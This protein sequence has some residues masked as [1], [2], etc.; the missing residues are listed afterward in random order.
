MK[1]CFCILTLNEESQIQDC[2]DSTKLVPHH[3]FI[4]D[5]GSNDKTIQIIE[6]N[7]VD[8]YVNKQSSNYCA[9]TQ[10]NIGLKIAKEYGYSHVFFID[11]DER[12]NDSSIDFINNNIN[13]LA[14]YE[15]VSIPLKYFLYGTFVRSQG[16]PNWHDRIVS[17]DSKFCGS[18]G[19]HINTHSKIYVKELNL[20]H[21]FNSKG[22]LRLSSNYSRYAS[23]IGEELFNYRQGLDSDYYKKNDGNGALKRYA[24]KLIWSRPFARFFW[25]YFWKRGFL[26]GKAGLILAIHNAYFELLIAIR[27][28]ELKRT[29]EG[30]GL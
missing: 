29:K 26:E 17:V 24:S 22:I 3:L 12:L 8:Y 28:T 5:S 23:Y 2:I 25:N 6:K 18:V 16:Y 7:E 11:A 21:F 10:R 15:V 1:L 20:D 9:A 30:K 13:S 27:Y 14:S 19:E 4:I